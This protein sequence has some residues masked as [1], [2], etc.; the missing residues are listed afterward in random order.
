LFFSKSNVVAVRFVTDFIFECF[1]RKQS[2]RLV[3]FFLLP[4]CSEGPDKR[5]IVSPSPTCHFHLELLVALRIARAAAIRQAFLRA[6]KTRPLCFHSNRRP[7]GW[8][9][10]PCIRAR[11]RE[12]WNSTGRTQAPRRP[13][14][15]TDRTTPKAPGRSRRPHRTAETTPH[16]LQ[17]SGQ[18]PS[19]RTT[20]CSCKLLAQTMN[21]SPAD[22]LLAQP[23]CS[24]NNNNLTDFHELPATPSPLSFY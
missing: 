20:N 17:T 10:A 19:S 23:M 14:H 15:R 9:T 8:T 13:P 22:G 21:C 11:T 3:I 24:A 16:L 12:P 6:I 4:S 2:T 18:T 5:S 1:K 7:F